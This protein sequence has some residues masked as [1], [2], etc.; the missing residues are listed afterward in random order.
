MILQKGFG[1]HRKKHI[2][3]PDEIFKKRLER[4]REELDLYIDSH[5]PISEHKLS[6]PM[7]DGV[8]CV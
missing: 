7:M 8:R 3:E 6:A 4:I 5:L 2:S 1:S